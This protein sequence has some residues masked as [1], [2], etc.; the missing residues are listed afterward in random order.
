MPA[1]HNN[2]RGPLIWQRFVWHPLGIVLVLLLAHS[3]IEI[4]TNPL[5]VGTLVPPPLRYFWGSV[6]VISAA[7]SLYGIFAKNGWLHRAGMVGLA[8]TVA[9]F[10]VVIMVA[11]PDHA[12][13]QALPDALACFGCAVRAIYS[14]I[15]L[16]GP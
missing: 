16:E 2:V 4:L 11:A 6:L 9:Y 1:R 12:L 5:S 7:V 3:G 13:G 8:G 14:D 10:V 15:A